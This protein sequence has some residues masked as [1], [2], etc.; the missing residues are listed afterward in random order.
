MRSTDSTVTPT[1]QSVVA[2]MLECS[3]IPPTEPLFT[4]FHL[5]AVSSFT[6]LLNLGVVL[7][8]FFPASFALADAAEEKDGKEESCCC[9]TSTVNGELGCLW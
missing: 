1:T 7:F 3:L 4:K 9:T 8:T 5:I 2:L 6:L